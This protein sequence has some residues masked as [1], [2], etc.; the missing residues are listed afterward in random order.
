MFSSSP[1]SF[2]VGGNDGKIYA[3]A[4][5]DREMVDSY[6]MSLIATD[7]G[8]LSATTLILVI[9]LDVNDETPTFRPD[10]FTLVLFESTD[11]SNALTVFVSLMVIHYS[12]YMY[13]VRTYIL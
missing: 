12:V 13:T 7:N 1:P 3:T 5:L 4:E 8:G 9:I 6:H 11:Y 2:S 10:M